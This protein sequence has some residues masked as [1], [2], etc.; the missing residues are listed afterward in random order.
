MNGSAEKEVNPIALAIGSFTSS[1][2]LS[3][4]LFQPLGTDALSKSSI[5]SPEI[6]INVQIRLQNPNGPL[7]EFRTVRDLEKEY[8]GYHVVKF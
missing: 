6:Q 7:R 5:V 1:A 2:S 4:P 8:S 3:A